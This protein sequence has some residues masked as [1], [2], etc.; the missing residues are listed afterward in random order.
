MRGRGFSVSL[1]VSMNPCR[2]RNMLLVS[3]QHA[4]ENIVSQDRVV[5]MHDFVVHPSPCAEGSTT[6]SRD[7]PLKQQHHLV[8]LRMAHVVISFSKLGNNVR[9][10]ATVR[11]DVMDTRL[12]RHM[13]PHHIDHV[14]HGF[15]SVERRP[16]SLG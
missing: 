2:V 1:A 13:L 6:S 14:I 10:V 5:P 11:N 7:N 8:W 16:P 4:R 15:N 3:I 12:R 9:R